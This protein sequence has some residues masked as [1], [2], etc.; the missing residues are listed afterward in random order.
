[1]CPIITNFRTGDLHPLLMSW[2][3]SPVGEMI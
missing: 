3:I 1:M 2:V